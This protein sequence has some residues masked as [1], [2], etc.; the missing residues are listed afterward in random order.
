MLTIYHLSN[1]RSE[2]IIWL[3]E[4]LGEP[5]E[6]IEVAREESGRAPAALQ[7]IHPLGKAPMIRDG[8]LTLIESGAIVEYIL[9]RYGKGR[10]VPEEASDAYPQYLLWM[11]FSEGSAMHSFLMNMFINML[12]GGEDEKS[13]WIPYLK[14]GA[15][16]Q[17]AFIEET[18][19]KQPYFAGDAFSAADIMMMFVFAAIERILQQPLTDYANIQAY[20]AR[21]G[22]RPAYHKAMKIANPEG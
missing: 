2:R 11:H 3:M 4:E 6:L 19:G 16:K 17:L 13:P 22:E 12:T 5:Y 14:E 15:N 1:S 10:L 21:I 9:S 18:L 8:K 7:E 20:L